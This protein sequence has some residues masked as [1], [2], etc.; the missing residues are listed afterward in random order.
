M[1][2]LF[3]VRL[4]NKSL[5]SVWCVGIKRYRQTCT[6]LLIEADRLEINR[7]RFTGHSL[8]HQTTP[9]DFIR[10]C[11]SHAPPLALLISGLAIAPV[12]KVLNVGSSFVHSLTS[13]TNINDV[14]RLSAKMTRAWMQ[15]R[16][17]N[18]AS[19][20]N[21][22]LSDEKISS[23]FSHSFSRIRWNWL[24]NQSA[25]ESSLKTVYLKCIALFTL[26]TD[27]S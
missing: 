26:R 9:G 18:H 3:T 16:F 20:W 5:R 11:Q 25:A 23:N 17:T 27:F 21:G 10:R 15:H 2:L 13:A 19:N 24:F 4:S 14:F 12:P 6:G 1:W 22:S 7:D 8:R